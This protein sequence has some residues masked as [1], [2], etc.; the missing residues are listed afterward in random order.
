MPAL[1]TDKAIQRLKKKIEEDLGPD[2]LLEVHN[3]LFADDPNFS[4][5]AD[6]F[7]I[8]EQLVNHLNGGLDP[9]EILQM[10]N[11]VCPADRHV[12]H[13]EANGI[14]LYNEEEP[15]PVD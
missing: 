7:Q 3:E 10:W 8:T 15:Q 6:P 9:E 4:E 11:L 12:W 13:D 14:Y 5:E 1:S 2:E